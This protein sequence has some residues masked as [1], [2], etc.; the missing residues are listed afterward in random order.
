MCAPWATLF[1]SFEGVVPV[2]V[3]AYGKQTLGIFLSHAPPCFLRQ[4][5]SLKLEFPH[6]ARLAS[7]E[8]SCL[9]PSSRISGYCT[10]HSIWVPGIQTLFSG[11]RGKTTPTEPCPQS[12][13]AAFPTSG[14]T[15]ALV[16]RR[17]GQQCKGSFHTVERMWQD[18]K[19]MLLVR[20]RGECL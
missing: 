11:L 20:C 19:K 6:S 7:Q 8:A 9:P 18:P 13:H 3:C 16:T 12:P 4:G 15:L 10:Q 17:R 5:P 1:L 14:N 2:C